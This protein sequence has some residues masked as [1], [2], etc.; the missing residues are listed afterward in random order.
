MLLEAKKNKLNKMPKVHI[1]QS[2][3]CQ[4]NK[5]PNQKTK[6]GLLV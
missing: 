3:K 5:Y 1:Y 2:F 6:G 4:W